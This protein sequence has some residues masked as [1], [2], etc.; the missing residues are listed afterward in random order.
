MRVKFFLKTCN[1]S[2]ID[3]KTIAI[4]VSKE[5]YLHAEQNGV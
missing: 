4:L 5:S 3:K 1:N 2:F